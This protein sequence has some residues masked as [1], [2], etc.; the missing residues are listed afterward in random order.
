MP[1]GCSCGL[2]TC[3]A[4]VLCTGTSTVPAPERPSVAELFKRAYEER[5]QRKAAK[6]ERNYRQVV[7]SVILACLFHMQAMSAS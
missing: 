4:N 1:I 7:V 2:C 5:D 3:T 6:A